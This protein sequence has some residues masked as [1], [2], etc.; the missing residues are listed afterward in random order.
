M[1]T[2]LLIVMMA[3]NVVLM[4]CIHRT[5]AKTHNS[6]NLLHTKLCKQKEEIVKYRKALEDITD[7]STHTL[8]DEPRRF[9]ER[10]RLYLTAQ[11]YQPTVSTSAQRNS[12][13]K[14]QDYHNHHTASVNDCS[15]SR[16]HGDSSCDS[17]NSSS[18]CSSSSSSSSD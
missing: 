8:K 14:R 13:H 7:N 1:T 4:F 6:I 5:N 15:P 12:S 11:R 17:G 2:L 10:Q 16:F 9:S 3:V 18:S